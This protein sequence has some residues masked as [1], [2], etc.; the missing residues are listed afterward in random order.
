[1]RNVSKTHNLR[2][3]WIL[4]KELTEVPV[5][6]DR[7]AESRTAA[8]YASFVQERANHKIIFVICGLSSAICGS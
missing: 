2:G 1:M 7:R 5:S 3:M 8:L 6:F 4:S